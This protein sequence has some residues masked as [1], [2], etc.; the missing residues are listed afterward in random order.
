M[1]SGLIKSQSG[2][3]TIQDVAQLAGVSPATVSKV[4]NG[5]PY[6]SQ[7]ARE[8]V[9]SAA[10]KLKFRPNAIAR[11]LKGKRTLTLGLIT[12]DLEGVFTMPLMRGVEEAASKQGFSV[13][14]CN[15]YGEASRERA[16]LEVLLAKQVDGIILMSGYSVKERGAP[17]LPLSDLPLVYLYQY[18][19]DLNVPCV[20]PDDLG[21]GKLGTEHL[22]KLG[23]RRIGFI[24]GPSTYE[25]THAR[26]EGYRQSLEAGGIIFDPALVRVG[27]WHEDSG[28]RLA[29]EL[30]KLPQPPTAIFCASDSLAVGAIDALHELDL[31]VP[32]DV[33]IVGYDN[34]Q[35][36]AYQRPPLT[37][38]ALPLYEMGKLAGEL[39][40]SAIAAGGGS[41]AQ[42]HK[43]PC[44]LVERQSCGVTASG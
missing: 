14:L 20:V 30:M 16:H 3:V 7:E 25:A 19:H 44:Y 18:T 4:M 28:Y 34:R 10:T 31:R 38:V 42:L 1:R 22:L 40:L 43:I 6:V 32:E 13:F 15:S 12:N 8:K 23:H 41:T 33:A 27:K 24:N 35:F 21:G 9:M 11:S 39:L 17:A 36:A 29:H 26:L 37:T 2:A 5:A